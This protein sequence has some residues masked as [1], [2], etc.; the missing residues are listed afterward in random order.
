M[1]EPASRFEAPTFEI[2]LDEKA[3]EWLRKHPRQ[4]SLVIAYENKRC[5]GG[6]QVCDLRLRYEEPTGRRA[7]DLLVIGTMAGQEVLMDRRIS[8]RMPRRIPISVSGIGPLRGL[9]LDL[10]GDDWAHLL[11]S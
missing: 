6:A 10:T 5:C 4:G 9:S 2:V 8:A 11:Y 3:R 7:Q 1:A